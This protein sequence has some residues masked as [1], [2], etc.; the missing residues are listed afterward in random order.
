[1]CYSGKIGHVLWRELGECLWWEKATAVAN[2][3]ASVVEAAA[4]VCLHVAKRAYG[5]W[6]DDWL[7]AA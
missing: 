6:A 3:Q 4:A 1:M 5:A 7:S 2:E